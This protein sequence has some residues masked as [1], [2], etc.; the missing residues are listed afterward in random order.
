MAEI[1]GSKVSRSDK[2]SQDAILEDSK[3]NK[4]LLKKL[5]YNKA[6]IF[7]E[8]EQRFGKDFALD[9]NSNLSEKNRKLM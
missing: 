2:K 6:I 5:N 4:H 9:L 1:F 7:K 8:A 3:A